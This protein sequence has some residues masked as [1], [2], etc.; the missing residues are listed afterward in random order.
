MGITNV[1]ERWE[2]RKSQLLVQLIFSLI[3]IATV[4]FQTFN[5]FIPLKG[6]KDITNR[7]FIYSSFNTDLKE[8]LDNNAEYSNYRILANNFQIPSMINI[9]LNPRKRG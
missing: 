8:F 5:K 2:K 7:Y 1:G 9:Y 3:L 4:S 6:K